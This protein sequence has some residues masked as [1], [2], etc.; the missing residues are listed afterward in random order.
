MSDDILSR[1]TDMLNRVRG[2]SISVAI[3]YHRGDDTIEMRATRGRTPYERSDEG[4][5]TVQAATMDFIVLVSD[6]EIDGAAIRPRVGDTIEITPGGSIYQ[7]VDIGGIGC[8]QAIA[9][10]TCYRIHTAIIG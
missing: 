10:D 9:L 6:M 7:V 4:G 5:F 1:A 8:Y 2:E 3:T